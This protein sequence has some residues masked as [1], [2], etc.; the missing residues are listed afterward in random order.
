MTKVF[1]GGSRKLFKLNVKVKERLDNIIKNRFIVLIGDANGI[2]KSVQQYLYE[3]QYKDVLVY[4]MEGKCRNNF[5]NWELINVYA[6][7]QAKG[8]KYYSTKDYEMA[9]IADYGLMVWDGKSRGT[10]NNILNLL[11]AEKKILVY[12]SQEKNIYYLT[13]FADLTQILKR[14]DKPSL[15]MFEEEVLELS[16][17]SHGR[18]EQLPLEFV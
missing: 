1:I 3:H 8:F 18:G 15:T 12:F 9:K 2:D 16:R 10:L 4:C 6:D 5:G 7:K 14:C 13:N 17:L 11:K